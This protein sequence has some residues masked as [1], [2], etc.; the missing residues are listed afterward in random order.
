[1]KTFSRIQFLSVVLGV[2]TSCSMGSFV[3]DSHNQSSSSSI[4]YDD[5]MVYD[6]NLPLYASLDGM[7]CG[8]TTKGASSEGSVQTLESLLDRSSTRIKTFG[9]YRLTEIPF[10]SNS[11]PSSAL[12]SDDV[13]DSVSPMSARSIGLFL[14]ETED[15]S[16]GVVDRKVVTMIPDTSYVCPDSP[17]DLSFINKGVFSGVV[18]FSDLDG[19]FRDVY[20]YGGDYC[21]I[22]DAEII[23]P[24]S[25]DAYAHSGYLSVLS[26]IGTRS[27]ED[28]AMVEGGILIEGSICI[29]E[30]TERK[31]LYPGWFDEGPDEDWEDGQQPELDTGGGGGTVGG[32]YGTVVG[33]ITDDESPSISSGS[34]I[35]GSYAGAVPIAIVPPDEEVQKYTVSLYSSPGGKV[36]GSGCYQPDSRIMCVAYADSS[37]VFDRWVGDFSGRTNFILLTVRRNYESTVYFRRMLE[38]GPVRPCLDTL[39]GIMNPL[40]EM[41]LAPSNTWGTN[42]KGATFGYTRYG[43][44]GLTLHSGLDL[45]AEPGTEVFSMFDGT[46]GEPYV[47]EQPMRDTNGY[48]SGYKGDKKDGGNRIYIRSNFS[49]KEISVGYMHLLSG[50]AVAINPRTGKPFK[51]GDRVYQGEVIGYTGRSGNAYN[52]PYAHLHLVVKDADGR[53]VDP[54]DYINGNTSSTGSDAGKNVP[55]T[56]ITGIRCNGND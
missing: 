48:P 1:M 43:K 8:C 6:R 39:T 2:L 36:S 32:S 26:F 42:Y 51:P 18:L 4:E 27:G 31:S 38:S 7:M 9:K 23:E 46:V 52:V 24:S 25:A 49:G 45:Y 33:I 53:F 50:K 10:I 13:P 5:V 20:V 28:G 56:K 30:K 37:Y 12:L 55:S 47:T 17:S 11:F 19:T 44:D 41:E 34:T 15:A 29:A 54:E 3:Q 40:K 14:V 21:H 35:V 16:T 22:I